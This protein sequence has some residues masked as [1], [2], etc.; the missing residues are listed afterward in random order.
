M[1]R[2]A[3]H[4]A[5]GSLSATTPG[6]LI[7]AGGHPP[8]ARRLMVALYFVGASL[9]IGV[10]LTAA[11]RRWSRRSEH[12]RT[13]TVIALVTW[14]LTALLAVPTGALAAGDP[15]ALASAWRWYLP[16]FLG[17]SVLIALLGGHVVA[18]PFDSVRRSGLL[19]PRR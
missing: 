16:F 14:L 12:R 7:F 9:A 3:V 19:A 17:S 6:L 4:W 8:D 10:L 15:G 11:I 13:G 1:R 5:I 2:F 18:R